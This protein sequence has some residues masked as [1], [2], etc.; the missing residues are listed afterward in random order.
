[1]YT[2][3]FVNFWYGPGDEFATCDE[4]IAFAKTKGFDAAIRRN[5]EAVG[6]WSI[7]GGFRKF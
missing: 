7:I 4:A 6:Y 1:M 3:F 5:G 2:I